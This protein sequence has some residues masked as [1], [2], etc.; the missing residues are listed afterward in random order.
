[1]DLDPRRLRILR[2]VALRGGVT[3]AARLLN[4]TPSAVS[5]QLVQLESEVGI[6]LID[7]SQRRISLTAAG[8]ILAARA[9]RIEQELSEARHELASFSN[10][11]SGSVTIIGF[12][13]V[14][15][16]LLLPCFRSLAKTHPGLHPHVVEEVDETKALRELRTGG[17]D[18]VITER[19]D[20][21]PEPHYPNLV[22]HSLGDDAYKI[23]VPAAWNIASASIRELFAVPWV[24]GPP[25]SACGQALKRLSEKYKFTPRHDHVCNEFPTMLSLVAAGLGAAI[26]PSLALSGLDTELVTVTS[27]PSYC[28]RRLNA[29]C[30]A[31][32][33]G[34]DPIA[35][36]VT[37]LI[38]EVAREIG[39]L[40]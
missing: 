3:D 21:H 40:R 18:I 36:A 11:L 33:F 29:V 16:Y 37:A 23:V 4:L 20:H 22:I 1:M 32:R 2:A 13:T 12:Q 6:A 34:P 35:S 8:E 38:E 14:I 25:E 17:A 15:R 10:Q 7:R 30:R 9:E 27:I 31:P 26:L 28:S 19:E 39:F 24:I 5:Q